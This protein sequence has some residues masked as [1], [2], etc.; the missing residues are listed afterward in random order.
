MGIYYEDDF[1]DDGYDLGYENGRDDALKEVDEE[2]TE[3]KNQIE[4]L[5]KCRHLVAKK[6]TKQALVCGCGNDLDL[7]CPLYTVP[8]K[9]SYATVE[10]VKT[11]CSYCGDPVS[12]DSLYC[13]HCGAEFI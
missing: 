12:S 1:Y 9:C 2:I 13:H 8:E 10:N 3:L 5:S 11:V 6:E 4:I 7:G